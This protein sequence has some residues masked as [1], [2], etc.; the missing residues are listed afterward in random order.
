[1]LPAS[2]S[3][4][5]PSWAELQESETNSPQILICLEDAV[6]LVETQKAWGAQASG[7]FE[8]WLHHSV[9]PLPSYSPSGRVMAARLGPGSELFPQ[10]CLRH[11]RLWRLQG[12][13]G[14][15]PTTCYFG[16]FHSV[17]VKAVCLVE[18]CRFGSDKLGFSLQIPVTVHVN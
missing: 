7:R 16:C 10:L 1:M 6:C 3:C 17:T 14:C 12:D 9:C 5:Q 2:V 13:A 11:W 18:E 4:R 8:Q 15:Q